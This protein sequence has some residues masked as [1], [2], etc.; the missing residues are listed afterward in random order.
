MLI[1]RSPI[2]KVALSVRTAPGRPL[3]TRRGERSAA[4]RPQ[5]PAVL[6]APPSPCPSPAMTRVRWRCD[7]RATQRSPCKPAPP[8][9][10][11]SRLVLVHVRPAALFIGSVARLA[12][13]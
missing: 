1:T 7:G 2:E 13:R 5:T 10:R 6:T 12:G 11:E 9:Y 4:W 3:A 8:R